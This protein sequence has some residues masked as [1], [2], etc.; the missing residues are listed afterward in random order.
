[1]TADELSAS[2]AS[3]TAALRDLDRDRTGRAVMVLE[4]VPAL[5]AEV[6][7]L[8]ALVLHAEWEAGSQEVECPWC[9]CTKR[10]GHFKCRAFSAVGVVR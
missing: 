1:V 10:E 7:R 6:R 2:E 5:V 4:D 3:A 9:G 8:R